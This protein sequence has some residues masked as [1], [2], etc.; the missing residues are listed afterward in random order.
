M[1]RLERL[2]LSSCPGLD[3]AKLGALANLKS[4]RRLVFGARVSSAGLANI[5]QLTAL[6]EL[7][8]APGRLTAVDVKP[9]AGLTH[10]E[11]LF[12]WH[13]P[14]SDQN[15]PSLQ[16]CREKVELFNAVGLATVAMP[17]L[18]ALSLDQPL[19]EAGLAAIV[20][21]DKLE[22]LSLELTEV[23]DRS[24]EL[25]GHLS[26]L[27]QLTLAGESKL[28]DRGFADLARLAALS[29]L[30]LPAA[31]ITDAAIPH[32]AGLTRLESLDLQQ[33]EITGATFAALA[34]LTELK[35]LNL[36]GSSFSDEGC[37]LLTQF[38]NLKTLDLSGAKVTDVGIEALAKIPNLECLIIDGT[39]ITDR[40]LAHLAGHMC[41]SSISAVDTSV[42]EEAVKQLLSA[43]PKG[44]PGV[45]RHLDVHFGNGDIPDFASD[46]DPDSEAATD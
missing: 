6:E 10:L 28:S 9:L 40:G 42:A 3:G 11:S 4:L 46:Y 24:L 22:E 20:S 45:M 21:H 19:D 39:T 18:R 25:I 35:S 43:R 2:S 5:C 17:N 16:D 38:V 32:L 30:S 31:G 41:L 37:R 33:S 26:A 44:T 7:S 12:V 8:F 27:T 15:V 13:P 34:P 1:K 14:S 29:E 36:A 23:N